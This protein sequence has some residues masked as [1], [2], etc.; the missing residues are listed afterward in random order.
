MD[1]VIEFY[2]S[3]E[4]LISSGN[5]VDFS[6]AAKGVISDTVEIW[7]W[8]DKLLAGA[9]MAIDPRLHAI[10]GPDDMSIIFNG[11]SWN[12]NESCLEARSCAANGVTADRQCSWTP[13]GPNALLQIGSI[14]SGAARQIELRLNLPANIEALNV[15]AGNLRLQY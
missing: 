14:P 8:N 15:S 1:P 10:S 7:I 11:S 12:D 6:T 3:D 2:D 5:P 4:V 9:D 13:I